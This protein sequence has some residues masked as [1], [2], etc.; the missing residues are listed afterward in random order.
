MAK[1]P[2][3]IDRFI[4]FVSEFEAVDDPAGKVAVSLL[5]LLLDVTVLDANGGT[6]DLALG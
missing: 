4:V 3:V 1:A 5:E 2:D 6:K